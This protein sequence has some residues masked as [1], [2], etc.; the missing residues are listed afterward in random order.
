[1]PDTTPVSAPP[2]HPVLREAALA[3]QLPADSRFLQGLK[4]PVAQ[5][6]S[7]TEA[8]DAG[9]E[10]AALLPAG[11]ISVTHATKAAHIDQVPLVLLQSAQGVLQLMD[12]FLVHQKLEGIRT[13]YLGF[14]P[15]VAQLGN[16]YRYMGI[17]PAKMLLELAPGD[18]VEPGPEALRPFQ[19]LDLPQ[20]RQQRLLGQVLRQLRLQR[21]TQEKRHH[22]R[23]SGHRQLIDAV[24]AAPPGLLYQFRKITILLYHTASGFLTQLYHKFPGPGVNSL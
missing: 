8:A 5:G 4:H 3:S 9:L 15:A 7:G 23:L 11:D 17:S 24:P 18:P 14:Q 6:L 20:H 16:G 19:P 13:V 1:M 2:V 21:G 10:N 12:G 22:P